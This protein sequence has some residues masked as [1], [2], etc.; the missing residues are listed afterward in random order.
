[1]KLSHVKAQYLHVKVRSSKYYSAILNILVIAK[2]KALIW[3]KDTQ[4][5]Q[6]AVP[7]GAY[8]LSRQGWGQKKGRIVIHIL[9]TEHSN[10][11]RLN[12]WLKVTQDVQGRPLEMNLCLKVHLPVC[13]PDRVNS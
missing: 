2:G 1:M 9:Q 12:A 11:E 13:H 5:K 6:Q 4:R 3:R 7:P 10:A 8:R